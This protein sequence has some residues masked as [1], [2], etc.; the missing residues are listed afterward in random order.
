MTESTIN[1]SPGVRP[2]GWVQPQA[3]S[4]YAKFV[5][6]SPIDLTSS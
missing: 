4:Y 3:T 6:T 2:F 5:A 1:D